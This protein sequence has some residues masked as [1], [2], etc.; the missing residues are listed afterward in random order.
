MVKS[1]FEVVNFIEMLNT[2]KPAH[3]LPVDN[4]WIS[5]IDFN[6]LTLFHLTLLKMSYGDVEGIPPAI[7]AKMISLIFPNSLHVYLTFE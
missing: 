1:I 7:G 5:R 2:R 6:I 4:L 3:V